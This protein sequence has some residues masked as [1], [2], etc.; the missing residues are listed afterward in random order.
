MPDAWRGVDPR[1]TGLPARRAAMTAVWHHGPGRWCRAATG[2]ARGAAHAT[3]LERHGPAKRMPHD[4]RG[5]PATRGHDGERILRHPLHR[6]RRAGRL[7][8]AHSPIVE[9]Q[10]RECAAQLAHLRHPAEPVQADALNEDDRWPGTL[11]LECQ[12]AALDL[13]KARHRTGVVGRALRA[14]PRCRARACCRATSALTILRTSVA[15]IGRCGVNRIVPLLV[16]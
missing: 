14:V 4:M 10:T 6:N 15:G 12:R 13:E 1:A 16:T 5:V 3:E 7:T 9:V 2:Y 11:D 8:P